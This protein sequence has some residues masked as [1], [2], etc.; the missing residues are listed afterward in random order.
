MLERLSVSRALSAARQ[1]RDQVPFYPGSY[2]RIGSAWERG[3]YGSYGG[4]QEYAA[5]ADVLGI[6]ILGYADWMRG[7]N[8]HGRLSMPGVGRTGKRGHGGGATVA[9]ALRRCLR[10]RIRLRMAVNVN[11]NHWHPLVPLDSDG[12]VLTEALPD[13]TEAVPTGVSA[14]LEGDKLREAAAYVHGYR[15]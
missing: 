3:A 6:A 7:G 8:Q 9:E 12:R 4:D 11:G 1:V 13:V 5:V 2:R 14:A 15:P 10:G